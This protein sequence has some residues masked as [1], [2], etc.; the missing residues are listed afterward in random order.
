MT[1]SFAEQVQDRVT[2]SIT[3]V[4]NVSDFKCSEV[5]GLFVLEGQVQ[6]RDEAEMCALVARLVP[7][8][9]KVKNKVVA[10]VR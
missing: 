4:V 2:L 8:V 10:R 3:R 5:D 9:G 1:Q 7:G 6:T